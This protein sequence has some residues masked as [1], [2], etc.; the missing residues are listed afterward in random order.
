MNP[1]D[2]LIISRYN[3]ILRKRHERPELVPEFIDNEGRRWYTYPVGDIPAERMAYIKT[4]YDILARGLSGAAIDKAFDDINKCL[5][6]GR[7]AEAGRA[8][9][10]LKELK[11]KVINFDSFV[12]VIAASYVRE[13]EDWAKM[14][15]DIHT[16]KVHYLYRETKEGR[17]FFRTA[18]WKDCA[19]R[20]NLSTVDV[21]K[22]LKDFITEMK[23]INLRSSILTGEQ[24]LPK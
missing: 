12:N 11:D 19:Q 16:E 14:I 15:D 3:R 20:F 6:H 7:I 22:L 21:E 9:C 8:L 2:R 10:D 13:D 23:R 24:P 17:F 1:I 18:V 4:Q 5:A